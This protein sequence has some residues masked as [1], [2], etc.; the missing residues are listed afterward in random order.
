MFQMLH[1]QYFGQNFSI[2]KALGMDASETLVSLVS[3]QSDCLDS[4]Q[5]LFACVEFLMSPYALVDISSFQQLAQFHSTLC[6]IITHM[7]CLVELILGTVYKYLYEDFFLLMYFSTNNMHCSILYVII[8]QHKHNAYPTA[9][10]K[11]KCA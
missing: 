9:H 8:V 4:V 5:V 11:N 10:H 6:A 2:S 1:Y 3:G 7:I